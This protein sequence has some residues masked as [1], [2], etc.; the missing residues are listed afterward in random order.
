MTKPPK[1]KPAAS[2]P[3]T[4]VPKQ[5]AA[6]HRSPMEETI[7]L[8]VT[9]KSPA[10]LSETIW[11]L[12]HETPP[13]IPARVI[14]VTTTEGREEIRKQLFEP[15]ARFSGRSAWDALRAALGDAGFDLAGR[16]RFGTTPDDI[17][18]ITAFDPASGRS[19]E[20]P[21]IR[22]PRDSEV[23][24]DFLLEQVRTV[25]ENPDTRL[26]ASMAGG[27]KTMGALLYACMTLAARETDRLTHVLVSEP[28]ETLREFYFPAQPGGPIARAGTM[29]DPVDGRVELADVTFV[30]LRNLF[31]RE[32]GRKAGTFGRLVETCRENVRHRAAESLKVAIE[33][34]RPEVEVNGT[35]VKLAPLEHVLLLF[36]AQRAKHG[37]PAYGT[38]LDSVDDVN[39]FRSDLVANIPADDF[40]DWRH[41]AS[42]RSVWDEQEVRKAVSGIRTKLR[43][44]G[45]DAA[46]LAACLPEKGRCSLDL[47]GPL[48][49]IKA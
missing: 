36:L 2:K 1:R 41:A 8:A 23:A 18:V 15:L 16:L 7:L 49:H 30:A 3:Q 24:A 27:R 44:R 37:E 5:G 42:L 21:D 45:G 26:V 39:A 34:R 48:I 19:V 4:T 13:V 32:L 40:G 6:A 38:Y 14:A 11:A 46:T 10:I 29:F 43:Q 35:T 28:F 33:T 20:L 31:V 47:P 17:R 12:A 9:G 25:V 22:S